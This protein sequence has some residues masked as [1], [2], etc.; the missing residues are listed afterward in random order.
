MISGYNDQ[1]PPVKNLMMIVSKEIK[2]YGFIVASLSH[3]YAD[4]FYS[5]VPRRIAQ[6]DLKYLEDIK[7]GLRYAGE[8]IYEVQ[9]GKNHG[10]SV[11]QVAE[12]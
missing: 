2:V 5:T 10:K 7:K 3:K 12:E 9:A 11:V 1:A 4:E 8:A 6:G